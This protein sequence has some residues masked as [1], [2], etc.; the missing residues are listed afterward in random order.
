MQWQIDIL[1]MAFPPCVLMVLESALGWYQGRISHYDK[2]SWEITVEQRILQGLS[3]TPRKTAKLKTELIDVD[4]VRGSTFPKAKPQSGIWLAGLHGISRIILLPLYASWWIRETSCTGFFVVLSVYSSILMSG[5]IMFCCRNDEVLLKDIPA[6]EVL[7]PCVVILVLSVIHSQIVCTR[8]TGISSPNHSRGTVGI[9][10]GRRMR[11]L[12]RSVSL[13]GRGKCA[14]SSTRRDTTRLSVNPPKKHNR[15]PFKTFRSHSEEPKHE[16]VYPLRPRSA[17]ENNVAPCVDS[18]GKPSIIIFSSGSSQNVKAEEQSSSSATTSSSDRSPVA[19]I[20]ESKGEIFIDQLK[21]KRLQEFCPA[22]NGIDDGPDVNIPLDGGDGR[23][24]G[25]KE[26]QVDGSRTESCLSKG[27]C[28]GKNSLLRTP[29]IEDIAPSI[30]LKLPSERPDVDGGSDGGEE[31]G[32]GDF[33]GPTTDTDS[34][35]MK[36]TARRSWCSCSCGKPSDTSASHPSRRSPH[37]LLPVAVERSSCNSS[38]ESDAEQSPSPQYTKAKHSEYEWM[39]ITTNSDDLSYSSESDGGWDDNEESDQTFL[40]SEALDWNIQGSPAAIITSAPNVSDKVSCKIWEEAEVKKVDLSVL[41]ISSAVISKVDS[42]HHT[43][44]Y[45]QFGLTIAIVIA[46]VP[47]IYRVD[48][49]ALGNFLDTV[50]TSDSQDWIPAFKEL[51]EKLFT[52]LLGGNMW[53]SIVILLSS[54]NRL[55]L[56]GGFFFLLSVAERTFKQISL[57]QTL[58]YL[59]RSCKTLC[60]YFSLLLLQQKRGPQRSVD[61]IVSATFFITLLLVSYLCFELLKE[62]DKSQHTLYNCELF[63]WCFA[64]GIYLIRFMTLG[65]M[66]NKKYS[67]L[68]VLI[69]E[70]I[71]MYL[72]MEQK[73]QKKDELML[74]NNVLKLVSVLLKELESPFKISGLSANPLLYNITR[75]VVLSACSGVLSDLLGFKLKLHKIKFKE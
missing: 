14:C 10:H 28:E 44:H 60:F 26:V 69:T 18:K 50:V 17:S 51:L 5:I 37:K 66:I 57:C 12:R 40:R 11:S 39:G 22:D 74:A 73:P 64:I 7:L 2:Q 33:E 48:Y 58:C 1:M 52:G 13:K 62:D 54:V 59:F 53:S 9:R 19:G 36:K 46:L 56:A 38:C 68:S 41:D 6:S 75:L 29:G 27:K 42:L 61:V 47:S 63:F 24:F 71:N 65:A 31:S 20:V 21:K 8:H 49:S 30:H 4:L 45:L 23:P 43:T 55:C 34:W 3:Y 35:N 32:M 67:S 16:E 72:H 25:G 15:S 70:Q